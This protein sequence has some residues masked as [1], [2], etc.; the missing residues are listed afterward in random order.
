M[1]FPELVLQEIVTVTCW[2]GEG[3]AGFKLGKHAEIRDVKE[4]QAFIKRS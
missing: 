2:G 1:S 4:A 3:R